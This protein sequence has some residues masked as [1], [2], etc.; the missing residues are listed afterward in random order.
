VAGAL[1]RPGGRASP[2][3]SS[4]PTPASHSVAPVSHKGAPAGP[5]PTRLMLCT[6]NDPVHGAEIRC[7]GHAAGRGRG[8][9]HLVG[10]ARQHRILPVRKTSSS[11]VLNQLQRDLLGR[12][13]VLA[14]KDWGLE[15]QNALGW[16]GLLKAIQPNPLQRAGTSAPG[17][18]RSEPRPT[19]PGMLQ[20]W[21]IGH[22][23]GQPVPVPRHPHGKKKTLPYI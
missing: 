15:S 14:G 2:M 8:G 22:L 4:H 21:G 23:T 10:S 16:E 11:F 18:G 20:G 6:A 17:S 13:T 5:M 12:E 9:D 1:L 7:A 3:P 19:W